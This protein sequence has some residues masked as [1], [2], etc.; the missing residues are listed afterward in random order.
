MPV[1]VGRLLKLVCLDF[2]R[3][4]CVPSIT[5]PQINIPFES[6]LDY[7]EL[8]EFPSNGKFNLEL[9]IP[10]NAKSRDLV[11]M[12]NGF[13]EG[14]RPGEPG[15]MAMYRRF[16]K[17]LNENG[18]AAVFLPLPFHFSRGADIDGVAPVSRL[19]THGSHFYHGGYTQVIADVGAICAQVKDNPS[20]LGLDQQKPR[21]HLLGYSLGGVAAI[22]ASVE[23]FPLVESVT[24]LFS[25]W[26]IA[27][28]DPRSLEQA[29]G[30]S[31]GFGIDQWNQ[32]VSELK[33]YTHEYSPVF[34]ALIWGTPFDEWVR[35]IPSRSLFIHGLK[36]DLFPSSMTDKR[37]ERIFEAIDGHNT[38]AFPKDRKNCTFIQ[39]MAGHVPIKTIR[40][41]TEYVAGFISSGE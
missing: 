9:W 6:K 8:A 36:D 14:T 33:D 30:S 10:E 27:T 15:G 24:V 4:Y 37:N 38:T 40:Q 7:R 22:G 5:M 39:V 23:L 20:W 21:I 31:H 17:R 13:L 1:K 3:D 34:N 26:N 28:L 18:I 12:M 25:T 16:A 35:R 32:M 29:F 19:V 41:I 11:I 2:F